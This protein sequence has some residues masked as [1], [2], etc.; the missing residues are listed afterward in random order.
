M[1]PSRDASRLSA[2]LTVGLALSLPAF[3]FAQSPG[4]SSGSGSGTG[5]GT[6][7]GNGTGTTGT[8][9]ESGSGTGTTGTG[10]ESASGT[11][12]NNLPDLRRG[13]SNAGG[14]L[15]NNPAGVGPAGGRT[16]A[17]P[18]ES[19]RDPS[20]GKPVAG[21]E[22]TREEVA[23]IDAGL[24]A[25]A[26][27]ITDPGQRAVALERVARTKI[28]G[29]RL[30]EAHRALVEAAEAVML[31]RD[32]ENLHDRRIGLVTL[33]ILNLAEADL[34]KGLLPRDADPSDSEIAPPP[35]GNRGDRATWLDRAED[36]WNRAR[37][38]AFQFRNPNFRGQMLSKVAESQAA[39]AQQMAD[40]AASAPVE[41]SERSREDNPLVARSDRLFRHAAEQT[42]RI[43]RPVWH[44][45]ALDVIVARASASGRFRAGSEIARRVGRPEIRV[46]AYLHLAEAQ[47]RRD[48]QQDATTSYADAARAVASINL[49][50][51]RMVLGGILI[52]SL[53]STGR[54]DDARASVTLLPSTSRRRQALAAVAESQGRRGLSDSALV[55]IGREPNPDDRSYFRRKVTDGMLA[56]VEQYRTSVMAAD[57]SR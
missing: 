40:N 10:A 35:E 20:F 26:R 17:T 44:D 45:H 27:S 57:R 21:V 13:Q 22:V 52:D 19:L 53:I 14:A 37:A 3:A 15:P 29:E 39:G 48:L 49:D 7:A 4:V 32:S 47:T 24:L 42:E 16:T 54:F 28:F 38:L 50:D 18:L 9:T 1:S 2:A 6:E 41:P 5:T 31:E 56:T 12:R 46:A 8:G 55:W 34:R 23:R 43:E 33:A 25:Q 51:P 36:E 30:N 11:R